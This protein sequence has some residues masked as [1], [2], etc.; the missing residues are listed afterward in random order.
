MKVCLPYL[1]LALRFLKPRCV[2]VLA[3]VNNAAKFFNF[4]DIVLIATLKRGP[5]CHLLSDISCD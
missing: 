2:L 4:M 5:S 1:P 3:H